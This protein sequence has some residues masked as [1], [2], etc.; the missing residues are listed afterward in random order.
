MQQFIM[1][2]SIDSANSAAAYS[3]G[4]KTGVNMMG[5]DLYERPVRS[6]LEEAMSCDKAAGIMTSVPILHATPGA[7]VTHTNFRKNV[8][9]LQDGF[10]ETQPTF[11]MGTCASIYQPSEELKQS[12]IDGILSSKYTFLTQ[13]PA[14]LAENF[15][16]AIQDKDPNKGESVLACFGGQYSTGKDGLGKPLENLPFRGTDSSY[17]GRW[18]SAAIVDK[19]EDDVT[20]NIT[21]NSTICNHWPVEELKNIP[22]MH[23]NVK[24]ALNFLG[25]STDGFFLMYEQ[26][27]IDWAAY[28]RLLTRLTHNC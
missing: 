8:H 10:R 15:Y 13:D 2:H 6:I 27:D 20:L 23:E 28:V 21:P 26:G 12:M 11:A 18:C 7:F 14:V 19:D 5:V 22:H 16:D 1:Q 9:H 17:T 3:T 24:E 25:K 4:V